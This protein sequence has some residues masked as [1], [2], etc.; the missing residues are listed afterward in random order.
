MW[1]H[2]RAARTSQ[3]TCWLMGTRLVEVDQLQDLELS[4]SRLSKFPALRPNE[5]GKHHRKLHELNS[6]F[7]EMV[8]CETGQNRALFRQSQKLKRKKNL[9]LT[10]LLVLVV[11]VSALPFSIEP[12]EI[13]KKKSSF[14]SGTLWKVVMLVKSHENHLENYQRKNINIFALIEYLILR[15]VSPFPWIV[16]SIVS[17][18]MNASEN[19]DVKQ[20]EVKYVWVRLHCEKEKWDEEGEREN[21]QGLKMDTRF[22][23]P[24]KTTTVSWVF[25]LLLFASS[26]TY[27][28]YHCDSP[29]TPRGK[30]PIL[31]WMKLVFDT[32]P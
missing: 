5:R 12:H 21:E 25:K 30:K 2:I 9:F 20:T 1:V 13:E 26:T 24:V 3:R 15:K 7:S 11:E 8:P 17:N 6:A 28:R 32:N 10:T 4:V 31:L 18:Y 19:D 23:L 16:D 14:S 22:F 27:F 29:P